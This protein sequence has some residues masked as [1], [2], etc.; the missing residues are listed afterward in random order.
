MFVW[1]MVFHTEGVEQLLTACF[2]ATHHGNA[3]SLNNAIIILVVH[4]ACQGVFQQNRPAGLSGH[5]QLSGIGIQWQQF[6]GELEGFDFGFV[7]IAVGGGNRKR[8]FARNARI[9][10][11]AIIYALVLP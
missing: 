6:G 11:A 7:P 3:P 4:M 8:S 10:E 2:L 9:E 5:R 1:N